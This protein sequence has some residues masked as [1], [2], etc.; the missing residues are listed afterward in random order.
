LPENADTVEA[1]EAVEAVETVVREAKGRMA[2]VKERMAGIP[3]PNRRAGQGLALT[4]T[5]T[6]NTRG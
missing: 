5:A 4:S 3:M 2:R 1:F 6:V